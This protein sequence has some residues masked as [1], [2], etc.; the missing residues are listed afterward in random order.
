MLDIISCR[1]MEMSVM[2]SLLGPVWYPPR[3]FECLSECFTHGVDSNECFTQGGSF[4][5]F[6]FFTLVTGPRRSL[7]LK[8]S[9]TRVYAPQIQ[10]GSRPLWLA[11]SCPSQGVR[12]GGA[13]SQAPPRTPPAP[14]V[15]PIARYHHGVFD[16]T[17]YSILPYEMRF[18]R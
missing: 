1:G 15:P 9:D 14:P 16:I 13:L 18:V 7:S 6:V 11:W 4:S 12:G 3:A 17:V 8:L 10:G 5:F 2:A